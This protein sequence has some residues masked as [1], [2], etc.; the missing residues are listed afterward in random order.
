MEIYGSDIRG[1]SSIKGVLERAEASQG[2]GADREATRENPKS[3][4]RLD[5]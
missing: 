4:N 1:G 5:N 3:R 2:V